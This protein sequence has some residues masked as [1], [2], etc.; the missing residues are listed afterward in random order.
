MK[1]KMKTT[2]CT[3]DPKLN[4]VKNQEREVT[5]E[6][7]RYWHNLGICDLL[8]PYPSGAEKAVISA[9]ERAVVK[10]TETAKVAVSHEPAKPP[11]AAP[12]KPTGVASAKAATWGTPEVK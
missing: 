4:F 12:V 10:P 7:A 2:S 3:P 1:I 8:E 6:E 9:P 11:V 5:P